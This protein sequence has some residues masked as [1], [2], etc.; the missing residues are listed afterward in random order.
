MQ[1]EPV[2]IRHFLPSKFQQQDPEKEIAKML[3]IL[4]SGERRLITFK[5]LEETCSV[6]MMLDEIGIQVDDDSN[7]EFVQNPGSEIDFIVKIG[8]SANTCD[9]AEL[10]KEA[11]SYVRQQHKQ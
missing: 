10:I 7:L 4:E 3:I 11:E 6:Q 5:L 2:I 1:Q 8:D 9:T